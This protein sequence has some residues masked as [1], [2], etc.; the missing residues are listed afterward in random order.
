M[1][2]ELNTVTVYSCTASDTHTHIHTS[3]CTRQRTNPATHQPFN[4]PILQHTNPAIDQSCSTPILQHTNPSTH[5]S[6][7]TLILQHTNP[8]THQ[9]CSTIILQHSNSA[10]HL[11]CSTLILQLIATKTR[12]LYN[13]QY[14]RDVTWLRRLVA[15]ISTSRSVFDPR[16]VRLTFIVHDVTV[17]HVLRLNRLKASSIQQE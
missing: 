14:L 1:F 12:L 2:R 11:F 16:P 5:Q 10:A 17:G 4:A 7:S 3:L 13:Q 15:G 8:A 9:S 6:C